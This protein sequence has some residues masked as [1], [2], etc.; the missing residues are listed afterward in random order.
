M[1]KA[2]KKCPFCGSSGE[3]IRTEHMPKTKG[4]DYKPR[5]TNTSCIARVSKTF[6]SLEEAIEAWN[7]R[8][9]EG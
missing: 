3:I 4:F 2:M 7:R 6:R 9:V 1:K 5:C 8:A